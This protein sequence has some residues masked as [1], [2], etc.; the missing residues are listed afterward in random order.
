MHD[1]RLIEPKIASRRNAAMAFIYVTIILDV[2]AL[3][4][5][6]PVFPRLVVGFSANTVQGAE[7]YGLFITVWGLANNE[8]TFAAAILV[9]APIGLAGPALQSLMSRRV[10]PSEQGQLQ[11]LTAASQDLLA[12]SVRSSLQ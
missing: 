3:G 2:L 7:I 12:S 10:K 9:F 1:Q 4:I 8:I 6:I 5:I 11:G